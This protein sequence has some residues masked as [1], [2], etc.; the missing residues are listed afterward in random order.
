MFSEALMS[1]VQVQKKN[2]DSLLFARKKKTNTFSARREQT[3]TSKCLSSLQGQFT[4]K[5][6]CSYREISDI[7]N[8]ILHQ[9]NFMF[10]EN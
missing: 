3:A 4:L 7:I 10:A 8:L 6:W 2:E 1:P 5:H 9:A